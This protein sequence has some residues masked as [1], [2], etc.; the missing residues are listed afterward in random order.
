MLP[1]VAGRP[2]LVSSRMAAR[3]GSLLV[4]GELTQPEGEGKASPLGG[5]ASESTVGNLSLRWRVPHLRPRGGS[6]GGDAMSIA[7]TLLPRNGRLTQAGTAPT[8]K[9]VIEVGW[10]G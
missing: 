3:A 2:R 5:C 1:S 4:F 8:W 10:P 6:K 9:P 7:S